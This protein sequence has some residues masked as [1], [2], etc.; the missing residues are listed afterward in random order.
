MTPDDVA[1]LLA[2]AA[3]AR[4]DRQRELEELVRVLRRSKIAKVRISKRGLFGL[5]RIDGFVAPIGTRNFSCQIVGGRAEY[6][7]VPLSGGVGISVPNP[8]LSR[9]QWYAELARSIAELATPGA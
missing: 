4:A 2:P 6:R 9:D 7:S 5:G 1:R 3:A 8:E